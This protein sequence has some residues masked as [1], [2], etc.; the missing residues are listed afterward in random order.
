LYLCKT[1]HTIADSQNVVKDNLFY[2]YAEAGRFSYIGTSVDACASGA[3]P[4]ANNHK[5]CPCLPK[6]GKFFFD[7]LGGLVFFG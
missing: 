2:A 4:K 3:T 1:K 6:V 5:S 7:F